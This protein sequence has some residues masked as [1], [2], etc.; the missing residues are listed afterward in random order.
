MPLFQN[1]SKC[2]TILMK[3]T[4]LHDNETAYRTHFHMNGLALTLVFKQGHKRTRKWSI[5][6]LG[7]I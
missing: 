4:D 6:E 5:T 2:E 3:M 1:E 7:Q